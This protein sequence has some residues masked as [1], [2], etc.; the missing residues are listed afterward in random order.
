MDEDEFEDFTVDAN[1]DDE[2]LNW[3]DLAF[4]ALTVPLYTMRG[5]VDVIMQL[6]S[7]LLQKSLIIDNKKRFAREVGAAIERIGG[8]E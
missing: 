7:G 1:V 4:L 6:R 3:A 2:P 8:G 5:V